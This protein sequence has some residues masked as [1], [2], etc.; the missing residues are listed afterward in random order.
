M[1]RYVTLAGNCGDRK[2]LDSAFESPRDRYRAIGPVRS[3][4]ERVPV[5]DFR[6]GTCT[7]DRKWC[8]DGARPLG[9]EVRGWY[10]DSIRASSS[11]FRD[12]MRDIVHGQ[13]E[14]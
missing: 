5:T 10:R 8:G 1:D 2:L 13:G 11:K 9:M 4:S 6:T 14:D 3:T 12:R 7:W